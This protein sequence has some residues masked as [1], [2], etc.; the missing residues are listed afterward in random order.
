ME[1]EDNDLDNMNEGND[2]NI[3]DEDESMLEDSSEHSDEELSD[4]EEEEILSEE[5]KVGNKRTKKGLTK[6]EILNNR[7][8]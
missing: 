8:L 4:E 6:Q 3:S 5:E 1:E 2:Q 7:A